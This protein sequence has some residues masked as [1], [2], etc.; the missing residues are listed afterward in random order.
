MRKKRHA[1]NETIR[2]RAETKNYFF[3][4]VKPW[5][6]LSQGVVEVKTINGFEEWCSSLLE[7]RSFYTFQYKEILKLLIIRSQEGRARAACTL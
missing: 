2:Q 6:S 1:A 5:N 3:A 7:A 4:V